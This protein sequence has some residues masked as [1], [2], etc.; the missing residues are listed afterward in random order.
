MARN[1][2]GGRRGAVRGRTQFRL[3]N[4]RYAKV[5]RATG[6]IL[7]IKADDQPYKGIVIT[8]APQALPRRHAV[9]PNL[10]G[11]PR[12]RRPAPAPGS[13]VVHL[14]QVARG[15]LQQDAA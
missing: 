15:D 5:D 8:L 12:P 7:S 9:R 3:P 6:H 14:P 13:T 11:F 2:P 10:P 4:G 1:R